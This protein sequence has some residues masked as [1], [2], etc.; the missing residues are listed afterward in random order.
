MKQGLW[1]DFFFLLKKNLELISSSTDRFT[2]PLLPHQNI[3][4][5]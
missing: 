2:D 3:F 1:F 5:E 4:K